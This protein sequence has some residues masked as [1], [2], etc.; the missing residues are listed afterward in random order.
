MQLGPRGSVY[1][2][3]RATVGL[4]RVARRAGILFDA[5]VELLSAAFKPA[6]AAG[7]QRFRLLNFLH[8]E[9]RAVEI[10]GGRFAA[11]GAA[12]CR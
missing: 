3:R 9:E 11:F 5:D 10:P 2:K 12:I 6:A 8:T 1:S 7:A 4:T